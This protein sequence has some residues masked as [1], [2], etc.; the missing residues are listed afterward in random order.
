MSRMA[1]AAS[2]ILAIT[3]SLGS[4]M[5]LSL[6]LNRSGDGESAQAKKPESPAAAV[7]T[8]E[9]SW[10]ALADDSSGDRAPVLRNGKLS[11]PRSAL[12]HRTTGWH[13]RCR[14][15]TTFCRSLSMLKALRPITGMT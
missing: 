5:L 3:L 10:D 1:I 7:K 2:L 9:L 6:A 8:L 12:R 11:W 13:R 15:A 14:E 4:A